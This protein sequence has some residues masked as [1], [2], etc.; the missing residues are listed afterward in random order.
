MKKEYN[1]SKEKLNPLLRRAVLFL[2]EENWDKADE[3]LERVLDD[4]PENAEAYLGKLM[5]DLHVKRIDDLKNFKEPIES[6]SNYKKIIRFA[7][8]RLRNLIIEYNKEIIDRNKIARMTDIYDDA[9]KRMDIATTADEY[10]DIK[11]ILKTIQDFK[12][13]K[14]LINECDSLAEVARNDAIYTE[15]KKYMTSDQREEVEHAKSLFKSI[16]GWKDVNDQ[17]LL[18][19][20]NIDT[21]EAKKREEEKKKQEKEKKD[22]IES[23]K[24]KKTIKKISI[25]VAA[26]VFISLIITIII[27]VYVI[28]TNKYNEAKNMYDS[29]EYLKAKAQFEKLD[30]FK[31]SED[32]VQ[33]CLEAYEE[34]RYNLAV[35]FYNRKKYLDA[36]EVFEEIKG[37]K[38]SGEQ[39]GE[40]IV[41]LVSEQID[42]EDYT[43]AVSI[44]EKYQLP[45]KSSRIIEEMLYNKGG[46]VVDNEAYKDGKVIFDAIPTYKDS[47]SYQTLCN[48]LENVEVYLDITYDMALDLMQLESTF[49]PAA[50]LLKKSPYKEW[51]EL[52]NREGI[53]ISDTTYRNWTGEFNMYDVAVVENGKFYVTNIRESELDLNLIREEA[54]KSET[55]SGVTKPVTNTILNVKDGIYYV[56]RKYENGNDEYLM[57]LSFDG[58]DLLIDS[59]NELGTAVPRDNSRLKK[60]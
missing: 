11:K 58:E 33:V 41:Y 29:G 52:A 54:I 51:K 21:I 8:E 30:G 49:E 25:I 16:L 4:E 56:Y 43:K 32:M 5:I 13:A 1:E 26:V 50:E 27:K 17:I 6:N 35:D 3:Y 44:Y 46:E 40:C 12:D 53:Y 42:N 19:D 14:D 55:G 9:R 20:V 57:R 28:P 45:E 24:R 60:Q 48:A 15:A 39:L 7:D 59:D 47:S 18:C 38:D 22:H 37:Y 23:L 36:A 2:E 34:E 31:D 10:I